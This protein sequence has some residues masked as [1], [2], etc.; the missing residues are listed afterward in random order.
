MDVRALVAGV[1]RLAPAVAR[2]ASWRYNCGYASKRKRPRAPS[3]GL[4]GEAEG[5]SRRPLVRNLSGAEWEAGK[6]LDN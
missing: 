4:A 1:E 6:H 5:R 2:R 3:E